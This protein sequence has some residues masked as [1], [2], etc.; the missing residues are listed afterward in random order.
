M[1]VSCYD[2][3]TCPYS[4]RAFQWLTRLEQT[5]PDLTVEWRTFSLKGSQPR[6]RHPVL[7]RRSRD[8]S[9]SVWR[10]PSPTPLAI[11]HLARYHAH[12]FQAMQQRRLQIRGLV[13]AAAEAGFNPNGV[14]PPQA[15]PQLVTYLLYRW[16]VIVRA[17]VVIGFSTAG[18]LG[19]QLR[20]DL[21][22]RRWTDV[23]LVLLA[24][25]LLVD[26]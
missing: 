6:R 13:A 25:V 22:F 26:R 5:L 20:L 1:Q 11:T 16:E 10:W 21:S 15:L 24:Y 9:A 14:L 8:S 23:A 18:G 17:G 19:Y 3:Y 12:V 4:Y 2:D 7:V